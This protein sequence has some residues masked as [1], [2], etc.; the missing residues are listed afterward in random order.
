MVRPA[1]T[2][3]PKIVPSAR[4]ITALVAFC[5]DSDVASRIL[6]E[7]RSD[8]TN[9]ADHAVPVPRQGSG[10]LAAHS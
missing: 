9:W 1:R 5:E 6:G 10:R 2:I 4:K 7:D 3:S 8:V